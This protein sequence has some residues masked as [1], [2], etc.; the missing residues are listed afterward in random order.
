MFTRDMGKIS[1]EAKMA[2]WVAANQNHRFRKLRFLPFKGK[3]SLNMDKLDNDQ[4]WVLHIHRQNYTLSIF[5]VKKNY[6]FQSLEIF[7]Y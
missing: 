2:G 3:G 1:R 7:V 6:G 4:R 5:W